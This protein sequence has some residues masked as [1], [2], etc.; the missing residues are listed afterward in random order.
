MTK[1]SCYTLSNFGRILIN[2][3]LFLLDT[4]SMFTQS[5]NTWYLLIMSRCC[6]RMDS[7]V[8]N[9]LLQ[10]NP[11]HCYLHIG[12]IITDHHNICATLNYRKQL[13]K[14][15]SIKINCSQFSPSLPFY[16]PFFHCFSQYTFDEL[17][18]RNRLVLYND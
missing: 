8:G 3:I 4:F 16:S 11:L 5:S 1:Y 13:L 15:A 17:G 9:A 14:N 12:R 10:L 2:S 7:V 18:L 6:V